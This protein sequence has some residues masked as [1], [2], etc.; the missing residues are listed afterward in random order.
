MSDVIR[1]C[2]A[3]VMGDM[4]ASEV[5][6]VCLLGKSIG[7]INGLGLLAHDRNKE[8]VHTDNLDVLSVLSCQPWCMWMAM[9]A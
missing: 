3:E 6:S 4:A 7:E 5:G 8:R 1:G 2:A 9:Q